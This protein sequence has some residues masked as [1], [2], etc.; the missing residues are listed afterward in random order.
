MPLELLLENAGVIAGK[1][2]AAGMYNRSIW[3][4]KDFGVG[5]VEL[6]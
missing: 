1:V 5:C 6:M 3:G 2:F 4:R